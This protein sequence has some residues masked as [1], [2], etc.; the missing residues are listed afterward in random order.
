[1][2]TYKKFMVLMVASLLMSTNIWAN[3]QVTVIK[4]LNGNVNS[5]AGTVTYSVAQTNN[6]CTLTVK[7]ADGNYATVS[8]ISAELTIDAGHAQ[9]PRRAPGITDPIEISA[10]DATA[11]P[12][13]ETTYYFQMP[14]N[15]VYDVE[16]TVN[17]LSRTSIS[18]GTL[19][20]AQ[21][22]Y[23]YTGLECKPGVTAARWPTP[24]TPLLIPTT[25]LLVQ[26]L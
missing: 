2:K 13:G 25:L 17:F 12:S 20:L 23:D 6:Q 5:S 11:D 24:T 14:E 10:T 3:G 26:L 9:A 7:P 1:M 21:S 18:S 16:V 19:T 4:K 22:A 15:E 8:E